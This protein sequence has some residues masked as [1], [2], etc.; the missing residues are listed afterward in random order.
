LRELADGYQPRA[1]LELVKQF[2]DR[3]IHR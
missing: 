2:K 1:I 3:E